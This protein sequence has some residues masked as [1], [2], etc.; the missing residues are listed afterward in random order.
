MSSAPA[1][2]VPCAAWADAVVANT[3]N[4]LVGA[5]TLV[6]SYQSS[7]GAYGGTNVGSAAVVQAATTISNNGG[8]IH[9]TLRQ[10]APA[11]LAVVPVPAG[12]KNLPLGARTPGALSIGSAAQS[13]TL[14]PGN[15]V[16]ANVNVS[17]PGAINVSPAGQVRIWVTGSLN[18]GGNL[19]LRGIPKNLAFLVTSAGFVNVNSGGAFFGLVY[20]P[21]SA[22]VVS[23]P[24][25]GT[26]VGSS[27][28]LNSGAAVHFDQSSVCVSNTAELDQSFITGNDLSDGLYGK[29]ALMAQSYTAGISGTLQGVA[30]DVS[31]IDVTQIARIQIEALAGGIPSNVVLGSA[32][33]ARGGDLS[34]NTVIPLGGSIP[35]VAGQQYAI[36]V[37]YPD[38]PPF[39]NGIENTAS[40]NGSDGDLYPAGTMFTTFDGGTTWQS[41]ASEGFDLHFRTFVIPN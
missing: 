2:P 13:I 6:D 32:R 40:W 36:L 26:V 35:Q 34:I 37:D 16:A 24:V 1:D 20:A 3:G 19:N 4:V 25:F 28:T 31:A 23:G 10:H 5:S 38:A 14:A 17:A 39:V 18:L 12:A 29:P 11:G 15:Y 21:T 33:A 8:V 27:V 9:G 7:L 22:L 41:F 30:I